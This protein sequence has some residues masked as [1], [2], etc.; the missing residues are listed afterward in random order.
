MSYTHSHR[1]RSY[2]LQSI[3]LQNLSRP[4]NGDDECASQLH[5]R[6]LS[7]CGQDSLGQTSFVST[8]RHGISQY[9]LSAKA[10]HISTHT[11]KDVQEEGASSMKDVGMLQATVELDM[12]MRSQNDTSTLSSPL[13]AM[14]DSLAPDSSKHPYK[15]CDGEPYT[16]CGACGERRHFSSTHNDRARLNDTRYLELTSGTATSMFPHQQDR[17]SF[18]SPG[19]ASSASQKC[20]A[21]GNVE[22]VA[23][24]LGTSRGR[25]QY[26][27][28]GRIQ[29]PLRHAATIV[30][31]MS[32]RVANIS[33]DPEVI[34]RTLR[35]KPSGHQNHLQE[36]PYLPVLPGYLV[37]NS[38]SAPRN[39]SGEPTVTTVCPSGQSTHWQRLQ[40][41]LRGRSLGI[42]SAES[43]LRIKLCDLLVHPATEPL[44]LVLIIIQTILLAIDA[45][46]TAPYR[47]GHAWDMFPLSP[48][49]WALFGLF[50]IYTIEAIIRIVVSGLVMDPVEHSTMDRSIAFTDALDM[51]PTKSL[52]GPQRQ[53]VQ[54]RDHKDG[55]KVLRSQ[56]PSVLQTSTMAQM[57]PEINPGNSCGHRSARLAHRAY[58]RHSFNR[59]DFIAVVS[60]WIAFTLGIISVNNGAVVQLFRML[61]CLRIVRLLNLTNGSSVRCHPPMSG[62]STDI[63]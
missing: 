3:P 36:T 17:S 11:P 23:A 44:L 41:P 45:S 43:K 55:D 57:P 14:Y 10:S 28:P 1:G 63:A 42:F 38:E 22:A 46:E 12:D 21:V 50:I 4:T 60:Y 56:Q 20:D 18:L 31:N 13:F 58:L 35:Q 9:S 52:R 33:N 61:S 59:M 49:D 54:N 24:E 37:E 26:L 32:T 34:E 53:S 19:G 27:M 2:T 16:H 62:I 47:R 8:G 5:R 51:S 29:S 48:I 7:D 40:K 30:C 39:P 15:Q 6:T 25:K